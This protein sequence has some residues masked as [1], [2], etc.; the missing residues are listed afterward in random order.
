VTAS[1][2]SRCGRLISGD[3]VPVRV[4]P[5]AGIPLELGRLGAT[6]PP[7]FCVAVLNL[8]RRRDPTGQPPV[9]C[10]ARRAR[11]GARFVSSNAHWA[12]WQQHQRLAAH[13]SSQRSSISIVA[14]VQPSDRL[15]RAG[16][17]GSSGHKPSP[18]A[19]IDCEPALRRI[20]KA[21]LKPTFLPAT[22]A[23]VAAC[24][25]AI[26]GIVAAARQPLRI[27]VAVMRA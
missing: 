24:W 27:G 14:M 4:S 18:A 11:A 7:A 3:M 20:V 9:L 13:F 2:V 21:V 1:G 12:A 5:C 26:F 25:A 6:W 16:M 23:V 17:P 10:S 15:P 8:N 19:A 22:D